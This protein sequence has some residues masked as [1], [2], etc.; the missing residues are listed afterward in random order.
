M[1]VKRANR[2]AS[3]GVGGGNGVNPSSLY[4]LSG[5]EEPNQFN[6]FILCKTPGFSFAGSFGASTRVWSVATVL[7][8]VVTITGSGSTSTTCIGGGV[9]C[10]RE[11][12]LVCATGCV[13]DDAAG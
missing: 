3:G 5:L 7:S 11:F 13:C 1:I 6:G 8:G 10:G 12:E 2:P 4:F 9:G